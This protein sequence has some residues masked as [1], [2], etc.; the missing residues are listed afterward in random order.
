MRQR[1]HLYALYALGLGLGNDLAHFKVPELDIF[2][3][4]TGDEATAVGTDVERPEGAGVRREGL[5]EGGG[6]EIVEEE[7]A[8]LCSDDDLRK[9]G[10]SVR[11]LSI[12]RGEGKTKTYMP[13]SRQESA[14][15][16]IPTVHRPDALGRLDVPQLETPMT[17]RSDELVVARDGEGADIGAVAGEV[18]GEEL[19]RFDGGGFRRGGRGEVV[20]FERIV[21]ESGED[22]RERE[23]SVYETKSW[24]G[25]EESAPERL[26]LSL[27]F[28]VQTRSS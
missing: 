13:I 24:N 19:G 18:E 28:P 6:G 22:L 10:G 15:N 11:R 21:G 17:R 12:E 7:V 14:A 9:G 23:T 27:P 8:R 25:E 3:G 1:K 2:V 16:R 26:P 20:D 4:G 5:E